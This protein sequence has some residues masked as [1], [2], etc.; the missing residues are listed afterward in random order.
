MKVKE[1]GV[2]SLI[3]GDFNAKTGEE[4]GEIRRDERGGERGKGKKKIEGQ[5]NRC[6]RK[7]TGKF[8]GRKEMK[9]TKRECERR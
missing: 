7:K 2:Y 9:Y 1:E 5:G 8:T 6:G 3:G 4:S